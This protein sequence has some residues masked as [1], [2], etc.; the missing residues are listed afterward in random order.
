MKH[1]DKA[2]NNAL[3]AKAVEI[4]ADRGLAWLMYGRIGNHPSLDAFKQNNGF[5]KFSLLRYY[6]PVTRNGQLALRLGL[7]RNL[8][9]VLPDGVKS[10][11]FP[12]FNWVSRIKQKLII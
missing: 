3:I 6:V 1:F 7:H 11:L 2:V 4:C 8:K 10:F 9:D 12:L 5:T